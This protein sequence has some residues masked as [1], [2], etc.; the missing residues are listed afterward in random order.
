[1][2]WADKAPIDKAP[3]G[4]APIGQKAVDKATI[5][6]KGTDK[7][8]IGEHHQRGL[9]ILLGPRRSPILRRQ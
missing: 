5:G 9:R 8:T 2:N 6:H 7:K 1:M 3:I 4:K